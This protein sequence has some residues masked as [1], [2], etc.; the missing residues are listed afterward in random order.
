MTVEDGNPM[1]V[2]D[3]LDEG[4]Q[5][6]RERDFAYS[7]SAAQ[8]RATRDSLT[9]ARNKQPYSCE[10]TS[11]GRSRRQR[12]PPP[13]SWPAMSTTRSVTRGPL[14]PRRLLHDM[15]CLQAQSCVVSDRTDRLTYERR[16]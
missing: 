12:T 13:R 15:R 3:V 7:L 9:C 11:T 1:P 14:H 8:M 4:E 16:R 6:L 5:V 10:E 2:A